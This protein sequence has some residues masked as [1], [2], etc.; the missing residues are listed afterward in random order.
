MK[1]KKLVKCWD[2]DKLI[3]S[4]FTRCLECEEDRIYDQFGND[5]G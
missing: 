2:C 1:D 4:M 5:E 3:D